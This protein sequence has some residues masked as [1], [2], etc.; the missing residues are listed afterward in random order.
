MITVA[1]GNFRVFS[2]G[3]PMIALPEPTSRAPSEQCVRCARWMWTSTRHLASRCSRRTANRARCRGRI[4]HSSDA[5]PYAGCSITT[6]RP[7]SD[8]EMSTTTVEPTVPSQRARAT[9]K[10]KG[11]E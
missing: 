6:S 8:G 3:V 9:D 2:R 1:E 5:R 11:V 10:A 7:W 4:V